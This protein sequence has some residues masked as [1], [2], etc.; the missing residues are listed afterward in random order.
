M[1]RALL[2]DDGWEPVTGGERIGFVKRDLI[3]IAQRGGNAALGILAGRLVQRVFGEHQNLAGRS[4]SDGGS[5]PGDAGANHKEVRSDIQTS[6]YKK[7]SALPCRDHRRPLV[8][9]Y[10][11]AWGFRPDS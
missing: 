4:Q 7:K 2:S 5:Q 6:W 11:R 3:V 9:L 10:R 1:F 8:P